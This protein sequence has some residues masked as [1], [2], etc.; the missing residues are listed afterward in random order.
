MVGNASYNL[1]K[2]DYREL[3]TYSGRDIDM[4]VLH[5]LTERTVVVN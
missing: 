5:G 3:S 2:V 1:G 4:N